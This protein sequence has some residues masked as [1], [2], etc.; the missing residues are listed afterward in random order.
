MLILKVL[1]LSIVLVAFSFLAMAVQVIFK[2]RFPKTQVGHNPD[3]RKLGI[4][5]AK[6]DELKSCAISKKEAK[7]L[8]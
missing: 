8:A 1:L 6:C 2:G 7:A 3:M 4:T 5:C